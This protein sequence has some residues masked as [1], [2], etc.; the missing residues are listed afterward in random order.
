MLVVI[1][2]IPITIQI[3]ENKENIIAGWRQDILADVCPLRLL[4]VVVHHQ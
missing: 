4:P 2:V 1:V 3:Q